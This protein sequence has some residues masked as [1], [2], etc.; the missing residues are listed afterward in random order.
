MS[1]S[2]EVQE[3]TPNTDSSTQVKENAAAEGAQEASA[4]EPEVAPAPE[5]SAPPA[6]P[7]P[8]ADST[9]PPSEPE[10]VPPEPDATPGPEA[11]AE[12]VPADATGAPDEQKGQT[13]TVGEKVS[14]VLT[15]IVADQCFVDFGGPTEGVIA[16]T[17]LRDPVTGDM[18]FDTGDPL[19]A[20]VTAVDD[21]GVTLSR[22]RAETAATEASSP[23]DRL[24]AAFKAGT[25]VNGRIIAVNKWGLGV[26]L[27]GIRAF[28]PV[29]QI[30]VSFVKDT[31]TYRDQELEF[32]ITRFKDQGRTV[33][34]SRRALLQDTRSQEADDV[35]AGI[36]KGARLE[37][38]VTRIEPYGAFVDLGAGVEGLIHV[39]EL[40]HE[41]VEHPQDAVQTGAELT[42]VV[43]RVKGLGDR[44]GERISLSLKALETDPWDK[45]KGQFPP[46]SV[47]EGKVESLEDYG[48]I[49]A[50]ADNVTGMV[51]VSEI[52][53]RRIAHPREVLSIG[54]SVRVAVLELDK[55]RRRLRLSMRQAE[56]MEDAANLRDFQRRNTESK[57]N[58]PENALTDAL[59]RA[60]LV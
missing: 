23:A 19:E 5:T 58:E 54:D 41:R 45:V 22:E 38:T 50:L 35:R 1:E 60:R 2:T 37:G 31:A 52:A 39:S 40:K 48:A 18:A 15:R 30:D 34:V 3:N 4:P 44:R 16:A 14:G 29:S 56:K 17:E 8:P 13:L 32:K 51:H 59:K 7:A 36:R 28:C 46:G 53:D 26:D 43:I 12:P 33:V 20:Y 27:E 11:V 10:V 6:D 57:S 24:Y 25:P 21:G 9:P 47:V 49:V 55:R 42:V